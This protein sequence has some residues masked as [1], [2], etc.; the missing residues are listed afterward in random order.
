MIGSNNFIETCNYYFDIWFS[1]FYFGKMSKLKFF[2][3]ETL[4]IQDYIPD[5]ILLDLDIC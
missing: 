2:A 3:E 5:S 1:L 4:D